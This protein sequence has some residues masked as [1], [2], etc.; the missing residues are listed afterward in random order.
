MIQTVKGG[1]PDLE[2][3]PA[4]PA[5]RHPAEPSMTASAKFREF[6][7]VQQVEHPG[8]VSACLPPLTRDGNPGNSYQG[9]AFLSLPTDTRGSHHFSLCLR[10][11]LSLSCRES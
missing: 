8:L 5:D 10:L 2:T 9:A 4:K 6:P 7:D 3:R 1:N 11:S